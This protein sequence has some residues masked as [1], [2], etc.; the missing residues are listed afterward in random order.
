ML[1]DKDSLK[2]YRREAPLGRP[3]LGQKISSF[4]MCRVVVLFAQKP[5]KLILRGLRE[6]HVLY[7]L[8]VA[9]RF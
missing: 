3:V 7:Y 1:V 9:F 8:R 5:F 2:D 6:D 4:R